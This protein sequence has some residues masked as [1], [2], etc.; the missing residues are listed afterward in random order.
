MTAALHHAESCLGLGPALDEVLFPVMR[1][2]GTWWLQ[3]PFATD[4]ERLATEVA[5]LWLEAVSAAAPSPADLPPVM[6]ACGPG[7]RHTVGQEALA[8]LLR[9]HRH[10]VRLL[11]SRTAPWMIPNAIRASGAHAAVVVS[12]LPAHHLAATQSLHAAQATG[13]AVFYAG[14]A[15]ASE[16]QRR[17]VPG[18]YLGTSLAGACAMILDRRRPETARTTHSGNGGGPVQDRRDVP[19]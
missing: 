9:H 2:I 17:D 12:H 11:N 13:V 16:R 10:P 8:A 18:R 7:D 4:S 6:L 15:F 3:E 19:R 14:A 1:L 5:R